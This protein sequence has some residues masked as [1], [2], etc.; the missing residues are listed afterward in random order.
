MLT[1]C[2]CF[3]ARMATLWGQLM[4]DTLGMQKTLPP[5]QMDFDELNFPLCCVYIQGRASYSHGAW[6]ALGCGKLQ[7]GPRRRR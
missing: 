7:R 4:A 1:V 6:R 2:G 3:H 5:D